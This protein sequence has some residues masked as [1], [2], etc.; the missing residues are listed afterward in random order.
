MAKKETIKEIAK[1]LF[2]DDKSLQIARLQTK[3]L[4]CMPQSKIQLDILRQIELLKAS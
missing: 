2:P 4:K 1:R 3:A